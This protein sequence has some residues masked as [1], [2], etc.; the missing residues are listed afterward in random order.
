MGNLY[1][2][3]KIN[4]AYKYYKKAIEIKEDLLSISSSKDDI[5]DLATSYN[6]LGF[7]Y[8]DNRKMIILPWNAIRKQST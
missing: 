4:Q 2:D 3:W 1:A 7:L 6:N 5:T 8:M